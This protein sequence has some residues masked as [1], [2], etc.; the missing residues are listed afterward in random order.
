MG[1]A[2]LRRFLSSRAVGW[3]AATLLVAYGA[4]VLV[5]L[6]LEDRL[7][8]PPALATERWLAAPPGFAFQDIEL[9]SPDGTRLHARWFPRTGSDGAVLI[10]HSRAGNV[11]LEGRPHELEGWHRE[12]GVSVLIFD[13]P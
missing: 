10:C 4:L 11:T 9:T 13:Y 1:V 3:M 2:R 12:L 7:V 8:F 5:L 6:A